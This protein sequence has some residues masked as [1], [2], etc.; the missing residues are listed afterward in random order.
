[1]VAAK[2]SVAAADVRTVLVGDVI[3][4]EGTRALAYLRE[5]VRVQLMPNSDVSQVEVRAAQAKAIQSKY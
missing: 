3:E 5:L 2:G 4:G 1:M